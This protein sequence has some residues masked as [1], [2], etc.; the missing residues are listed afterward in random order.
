MHQF[1]YT[2]NYLGGN[3]SGFEL[4]TGGSLLNSQNS[5]Y[6]SNAQ[7]TSIAAIPHN[8]STK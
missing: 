6:N 2:A 1:L 7:P 4:N 3:V 5:P 8:G